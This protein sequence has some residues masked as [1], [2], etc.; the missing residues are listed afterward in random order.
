MMRLADLAQGRDNNCNL[1]RFLA[2]TAVIF[3]HCYALT[4]RWTDEPLWRLAPELNFGSLGVKAF[5][6]ISGFLVTKSWQER[7]RIAPFAAARALRIYPAL[8][9]ATAVTIAL[10]AWSSAR[11][12][13]A[14]LADPQTLDYA[15]HTATAF[16]VRDR[17]PSAYATNP[18]PDSVN[19]SLWTLPVELRLYAA[20]AIAGV[21]GVLARKRAWAAVVAALTALYIVRPEW[22]PL[23]HNDRTT[24]ELALLF[25][26]GS[27]AYLWRDRIA[28]S[29]A[30]LLA[31]VVLV[32]W[33][34]A[35]LAR[36]P[37]F[38]PLFTY[39]LLVAAYH[40]RLRW[41]AFNRLGDYSYGLYIY[42]FP[43]QQTL[44]R[45]APGIEPVTLFA[46]A[47]TLALALAVVSWHGIEK[48]ALGIKSRFHR[49][50]RLPT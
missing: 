28:L 3:F 37:L 29:V 40:P 1:I 30:A 15:W 5:F 36:G 26:M 2:A 9:C 46:L 44:V 21:A 4:D 22:F 14:F 25:A 27:L 19:G 38:E 18:F 42:S 23:A 35:A 11:P 13:A 6:V 12:L 33:N 17:L 45:L 34:P 49:T 20:L 8:V 41:P 39:A 43:I 31:V 16:D 10:A 32:A 48:P 50:E 7:G 24:R 47:F